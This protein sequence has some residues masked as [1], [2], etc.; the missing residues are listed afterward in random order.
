MPAKPKTIKEL[1][2]QRRK[3]NFVGR[4]EQQQVFLDNFTGDEVKWVVLSVTG[5]GG[6]GKST[7]LTRYAQLAQGEDF[8][9]NVVKCDDRQY[10]PVDAMAAIAEQLAKVGIESKKFD[11][12]YK[13][14]RETLQQIESD[15]TAPRGM[16]NVVTRGLTD[17]T[18]KSLR[19]LP[20]VGV[21]ADYV[22]EKAAGDAMADLAQ[23]AFTR[24]GNKDEVLLV[25]EPEKILT[26]LF[27][28]LL[29][30]AT[31]KKRLV[32]MFDVFERT[33]ST[34][35]S[36]II[37]LVDSKHGDL[38]LSVSFIV[39]GRDSLEQHW[40][41]LAG[42][43]AHV[44]LEPFTLDE[45]AIYLSNQ[46]IKDEA[47]V[48]QIHEDTGGLPVLVELL[49]STKPQPG[50][51]LPDISKDAVERFLQWT[52][53]EKK[54]VALLAAVPRQ[55][56][57]DILQALLGQDKGKELFH[58]LVGQSFVRS[59]TER[60]YFYHD[61]VR[62]LMLR[63]QK[64]ITPHELADT[65]TVLAKHFTN[66]CT[67]LGLQGKDVYQSQAW[68]RLELERIY[69]HVSA[70]PEKHFVPMLDSFLS[71][72]QYRWKFSQTL[73]KISAQAMTDSQCKLFNKYFEK[74]KQLMDSYDKD[75]YQQFKEIISEIQSIAGL[76]LTSRAIC[77]AHKGVAC[78]HLDQNDDALIHF[79][80]AIEFDE[81][82]VTALA[83]RGVTYGRMDRYKDALLDLSRA[84]ELYKDNASIFENRAL[85]YRLME[86][87]DEAVADFTNAIELD[88]NDA[89]IF[90][91]R[92]IT[93]RLMERY[94][95]SL[96]DF[97][98]AIELDESNTSIIADRG[99]T[100]HLMER[101]D[102]AVADFTHAIELDESNAYLIAN[103]GV[104]YRLMERYDEALADFTRAIELDESNT[105]IIADRGLT[106]RL[107]ERYDK[108][109]TDFTH[110]IELDEN[111][112]SIFAN[113]GI[114]YRLMERYDESLAD[115]TRA[116]ELDESNAYLIAKRGEVYQLM[117]R[118]DEAVADF[119]NAI[120]LDNKYTWAIAN[121][122][123]T[124]GMMEYYE[125]SL[126]D[127]SHA[128]ELDENNALILANR[129]ITYR[130]M[131]RYDKSLAD[132]TRAI[133]LDESNT[134]ILANRGVTYRLM[135]RYDKSLADFTRAIELDKSNAS[136][137]ADRGLTY[138]LMERYDEAVADFTRAI[139]LDESNAYLIAKRG[140]VYRLKEHF[141]EAVADFT[142]AIK[143]DNK[144]VWVVEQ[145]SELF[146][147]TRQYELQLQDLE[148]LLKLDPKNEG[149]LFEK[150]EVLRRLEKLPDSLE[151][152]NEIFDLL[153]DKIDIHH[154]VRRALV[155]KII[156]N[157]EHAKDD[158]QKA[159]N[160]PHK[161]TR[162]HYNRACA[163]LVGER[164]PNALAEFDM[165]FKE[166]APRD[167]SRTDDLLDPI[168][169][170]P[171]FKALLAK[172]E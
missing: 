103:R 6:V 136:I 163:F 30:E 84:I 48:K 15:P 32:V 49:A 132:F 72:F 21:A 139:E 108:A 109:V 61:K 161:D 79:T 7:L 166:K 66:R 167:F 75:D 133:E 27:V 1:K 159:L 170:L 14:Y 126:A 85:T 160:I 19:R 111:D 138:R 87:Y 154:L 143:L 88:D 128:L 121:R 50:T 58:W 120:E 117:E 53:D 65:H 44:Q 157:L 155:N 20:G 137:I 76:S 86:C 140:E 16:V 67:D 151:T 13:K 22:D 129:G 62:A 82:N 42:L 131:E 141:D 92:G 83:N 91:N 107:M 153:G 77:F 118:Y 12:R 41:E 69:H 98:R 119:T 124:Y 29:N 152:F 122:G 149:F 144:M 113:R 96:A 78:L 18:I 150:G 64:N 70:E 134:S 9:A 104:I 36:W 37:E 26:P 147:A 59:N 172:Y 56:N 110:A 10:T 31:E 95:E 80:R 39:S 93:Y 158:I 116:I 55:F 63:H 17:F 102:E 106:Y 99:V 162:D 125:E 90:A 142:H 97:T 52:P 40:T 74:L 123:Q 148:A 3:E 45:T 89:S 100:Y 165:A 57:Q 127:L 24:W 35:S 156:G 51:P 8:N 112:A 145:R 130:L 23:Y 115:F 169:D 11:E 5:E 81:H 34:L 73:V 114:T 47:L 54:E 25:R 2:E 28:E 60:G 71:A 94:D 33:A 171:E 38:G 105:S 68:R 135:E 4:S 43:M 146:K 101:Y 46:D 168:R 164:L